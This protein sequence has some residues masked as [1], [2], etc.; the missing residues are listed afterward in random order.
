M[1]YDEMFLFQEK[2]LHPNALS[3]SSQLLFADPR[4]LPSIRALTT[5][6]ETRGKTLKNTL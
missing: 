6:T 4:K 5:L 3:E 1:I 2:P